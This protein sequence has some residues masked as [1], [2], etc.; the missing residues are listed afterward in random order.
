MKRLYKHFPILIQ[1]VIITLVNNYK[2]YQK[3]GVIPF[4][5]PLKKVVKDIETS[6][7]NDRQTLKRINNLIN[8]AVQ[9]VPYYSENKSAYKPLNKITDL[10]NLPVLKKSTLKQE[11]SKFISKKSNLFNSYKFKTS[12]STGTPLKGA[13]SNKELQT[14]FKIFLMSLKREGID[15]SLPLARFPG[16][17]VAGSDKVYRCDYLNKHFMFSIY[18]LTSTK[19]LDY[20]KALSDNKIQI[21]EGYPSTIYSLVKLLKLYGLK[22][23]SVKHV[24]TTAEKLLDY[25]KKEIEAYFKVQI[26]DFYGSS[27]GSAYMYSTKEGYY[28]NSNKIAYFETVNDNFEPV[29]NNEQG[30]ILVTSF[31][32]SFTPLIRYDIGDIATVIDDKNEIIKVSELLGRQEDIYI[33]PTGIAFGR[34][35]LVLKYLPSDV[36][37]SQL[38]LKQRSNSAKVKYVSEKMIDQKR[39]ETFQNKINTMLRMEFEIEYIHLNKF[40]KE[41]R[42]KLSAVKIIE[43]EN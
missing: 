35:S 24:L 42:G 40:E 21:L 15:Y 20:Y 29:N 18:H 43:N 19:I 30:R 33:S 14:R 8:E 4:F 22:L 37:E 31:T 25:Q 27:E 28:L 32:S 23:D 7:F 2:Y 16:A 1:N 41:S 38:I 10:Q 11:N 12:G 5:K 13:I 3:F 36:Q 17:D 26:F 39:F 6:S 34:F 9:N